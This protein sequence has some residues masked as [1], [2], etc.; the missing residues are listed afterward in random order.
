[1][2]NLVEVTVVKK[3]KNKSSLF[4]IASFFFYIASIIGFVSGDS[5]SMSIVWLCLGSSFLCLGSVH[6]KKENDE[7]K[8]NNK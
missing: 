1:M 2:K 3:S 6:M 8:R 4:C 5:N 7:T